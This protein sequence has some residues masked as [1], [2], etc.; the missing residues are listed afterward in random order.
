MKADL[1]D[2]QVERAAAK[3]AMA[4]ATGIR[5][6]E[7]AAYAAEKAEHDANI[8]A[9]TT[10]V[11]S[12]TK[13]AGGFLQTG[14]A[15]ILRRLA[16][17]AQ[18]MPE[19]DRKELT[20]FLSETHSSGYVPQSTQI[21]GILKEMG[22]TMAKSLAD[23]TT[24]EETSAKTYEEL[25]AAKNKEVTAL[26]RSIETKTSQIGEI[27]V[28]IVRMKED[29]EDT[30]TALAVDQ[31]FIAELKKDCKTKT[32][33]WEERSKTRADE[34]VALADTIK[35]LNDDDALELFKKTL[36]SASASFVQVRRSAA[37]VRSKALAMVR[38]AMRTA[39]HQDSPGLDL[40]VLALSG[41]RALGQGGFD[42]VIKM[43]DSMVEVLKKEQD[44]DDH[45]KEY[46][47]KQFD[48]SDDKKKGLE[49][50]IS[51]QENAIATAKDGIATV[52]EEIASLE[53]GIVALDKSVAEATEQRKEENLEFKDLMSSNAAAKEL[54]GF[55]KNRLNKFYNPKL[56]KPPPKA[57]LSAHDRIAANMGV[58]A[59]F[60]QISAHH[61][62]AMPPPPETWDAY[63][64]KSEESTGVMA[65]M[66]LLVKD[67]DKEMVEAEAE[68]KDAQAD[69]EVAMK[70]S[71]EKRTADSKSL[72][73]KG[74]FK[75]DLEG[76]L[77]GHK[78]S[79]AD[80]SKELMATMKYIASL[81]AECDWLLKY[82]DVRKEAR[83][84]EI[85]SL[86]K[87]KAVLSG[88][89]YSLAQTKMQGFLKR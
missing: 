42:K 25:M 29:S 33:Q 11:A 17:S 21:I 48:F 81:H 28:A 46:C 89:D 84:G 2:A 27:G 85:D 59:V 61:Q 18:E 31:K 5:E 67:L 43:C 86:Q 70:D 24:A 53:A 12:L 88:A 75:A 36:P 19:E 76:A 68:E 47:G 35:L 6:K 20:S 71:A 50:T 57:E 65:M 4:Q 7:A 10:A 40:L 14:A 49:Q 39:N 79:K 15:Q 52:T 1:K 32:S 80:A 13:G 23:A 3:E 45:K 22:D 8:G 72:T 37:S 55:A 87:A 66:D 60:V 78:E 58:A 30:A 64:K 83:A 26:T 69:Y 62:S 51:D 54:I 16:L 34:L 41:K 74:A 38:G 63:A 44:D 56:Y 77:E 73:A 9:I 82:F